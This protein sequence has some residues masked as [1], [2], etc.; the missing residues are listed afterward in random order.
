[1]PRLNGV[2]VCR[3]TPP[4][5]A[6]LVF[7]GRL[8]FSAPGRIPPGGLISVILSEAKD[9]FRYHGLCREGKDPSAFRP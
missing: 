6:S 7:C 4:G 9:L 3:K 5:L 2:R 1:M 8:F